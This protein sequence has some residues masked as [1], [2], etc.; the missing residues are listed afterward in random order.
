LSKV[1]GKSIFHVGWWCELDT[2]V[3]RAAYRGPRSI[4]W[5]VGERRDLGKLERGVV[6]SR[7]AWDCSLKQLVAEVD[8]SEV[9]IHNVCSIAHK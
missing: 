5:I 4:V 3:G 2:C 7:P 8:L 6:L 9:K 1:T